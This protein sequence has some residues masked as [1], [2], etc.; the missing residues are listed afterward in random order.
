MATITQLTKKHTPQWTLADRMRKSRTDAGLTAQ[1]I[2]DAIG[3]SRK[4][5]TN[6]ETGST[7]PLRPILAAWAEVTGTYVEWLE[8]GT[9][10]FPRGLTDTGSD[11]PTP[12]TGRYATLARVITLRAVA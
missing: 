4:S 12:D 6:Y 3:I 8:S 10:P 5:V 2:A 9:A 7:H 11:T 1:Q